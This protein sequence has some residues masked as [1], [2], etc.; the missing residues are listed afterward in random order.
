M[1]KKTQAPDFLALAEQLKKGVRIYAKVYC[2]NF[3]KDTFR[4][5]GF[6]DVSFEAWEKRKEPDRRPGGAI[7]V[8]TTFLRNSLEVLDESE[9]TIE[10]G[11]HTPYAAVHN[12]GLR[13]RSIQN[14]RGYHR[15]RKGNREQVR[16][17]YRKQDTQYRK[18]QFI[19]HST[20]MMQQLNDW[21]IKD[22]LKQFKEHLKK[23]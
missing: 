18:R 17:H 15:T 16:P 10:F 23:D 5:Q 20:Q 11:T 12:N 22:I 2:L 7:L 9:N 19:G 6:T 13:V 14:V 4:D 21:M 8:D 3:F 1:S